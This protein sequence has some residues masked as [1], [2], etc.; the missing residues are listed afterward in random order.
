MV[1]SGP[2]EGVVAVP[3][4]GFSCVWLQQ[5]V[6]CDHSI[7]VPCVLF[8]LAAGGVRAAGSLRFVLGGS[9]SHTQA[10]KPA[11]ALGMPS[12]GA[13]GVQKQGVGSISFLWTSQVWLAFHL[14]L[15]DQRHPDSG[16]RAVL[17]D[18]GD[19]KVRDQLVKFLW[20]RF[21]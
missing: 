10:L 6:Y 17:P 19:P 1:V 9:C 20:A 14:Y 5:P 15:H 16:Q 2:V 18:Y 13:C 11:L 4:S 8:D 21:S 7:C 12:P 3:G